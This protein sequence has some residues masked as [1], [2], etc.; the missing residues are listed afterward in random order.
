M[1]DNNIPVTIL[2][3]IFII[4]FLFSCDDVPL[5]YK[6][7]DSVVLNGFNIKMTVSDAN[8]DFREYT[9]RW[10]DKD[11]KLQHGEFEENELA[12]FAARVK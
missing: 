7:G 3:V 6:I 8:L 9:C 4:L 12:S 5:K 11:G 1:S 2:V 10:Y